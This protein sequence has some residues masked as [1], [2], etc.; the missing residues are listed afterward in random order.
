MEE[1]DKTVVVMLAMILILILLI[2]GMIVTSDYL[3]TKLETEQPKY[4][5]EFKGNVYELKE[6]D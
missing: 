4:F 1:I 6:V 5:I 2:F 3:T